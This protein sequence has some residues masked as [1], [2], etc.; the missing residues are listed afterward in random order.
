[1]GSSSA[2]DQHFSF[3]VCGF[4]VDFHSDS[5]YHSAFSWQVRFAEFRGP[6]A[7][8]FTVRAATINQDSSFEIF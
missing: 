2:F 3:V 5:T 6:T 4:F 8:R 7:E 1:L